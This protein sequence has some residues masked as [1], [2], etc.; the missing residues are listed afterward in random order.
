MQPTP[1]TYSPEEII[2]TCAAQFIA[3]RLT[4]TA[5][6][7]HC[8]I[9]PDGAILTGLFAPVADTAFSE[10]MIALALHAKARL[11]RIHR[12]LAHFYTL[13]SGAHPSGATHYGAQQ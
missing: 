4:E 6:L 5:D 9:T 1:P 12:E 7:E 8:P 3:F 10:S 2:L 13:Q 11:L